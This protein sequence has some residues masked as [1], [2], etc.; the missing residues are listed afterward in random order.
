MADHNLRYYALAALTGLTA[1]GWV[2]EKIN[3]QITAA[4]FVTITAIVAA[5]I[6]KH[7]DDE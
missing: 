7:R 5:D 1:L 2:L 4:V 3:G 6:Y